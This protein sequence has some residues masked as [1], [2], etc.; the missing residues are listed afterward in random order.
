MLKFLLTAREVLLCADGGWSRMRARTV[1]LAAGGD[2]L[3]CA[4]ARTGGIYNV[5]TG[6][7]AALLN[8][9]QHEKPPQPVE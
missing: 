7:N 9:R 2:A 1:E 6:G 5:K 3:V 4:D 8:R